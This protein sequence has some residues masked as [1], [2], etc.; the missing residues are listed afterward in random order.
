[1]FVFKGEES[2]AYF[3]EHDQECTILD[4]TGQAECAALT[5]HGC[6]LGADLPCARNKD[7]V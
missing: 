6:R 7:A 5:A 1:M 2:Y 3:E 4:Q